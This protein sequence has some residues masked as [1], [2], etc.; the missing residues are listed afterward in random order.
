MLTSK[1]FN[2]KAG[3]LLNDKHL[4]SSYGSR[5]NPYDYKNELANKQQKISE[6]QQ[7][8]Q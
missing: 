8:W 3:I 6:L 4:A 7:F 5:L 2:L 1:T